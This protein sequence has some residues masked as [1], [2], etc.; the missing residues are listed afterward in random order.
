L[1]RYSEQTKRCYSVLEGQLQKSGGSSILPGKVTAVDFHFE[2]WVR[3]HSFAGLSL[4]DYPTVTKWLGQIG[5]RKEVQQ[6]Y[7]KIKGS[8]S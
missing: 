6:A 4:D 2:P 1:E 5:T 8:S 7:T 3:Q